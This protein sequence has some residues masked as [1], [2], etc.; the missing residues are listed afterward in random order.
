MFDDDPDV[1]DVVLPHGQDIK[2][3]NTE[4]VDDAY[5]EAL[6]EYIGNYTVVPEKDYISI[7]TKFIGR[8]RYHSGNR[9]DKQNKNPILGTIIYGLEFL[10]GCKEEW[11]MNTILEKRLE[12][13]DGD[14]WDTALLSETISFRSDPNAAIHKGEN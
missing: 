13:V 3:Q 4:E 14:G 2:D 7:L 6:E 12:Q 11:W 1:D 8:N 10:Y 5:V 9:A